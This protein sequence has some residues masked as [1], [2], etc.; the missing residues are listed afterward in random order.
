MCPWET[1]V[2]VSV[3]DSVNSGWKPPHPIYSDLIGP[4]AAGELGLHL[5]HGWLAA[6]SLNG[7]EEAGTP[8]MLE[9]ELQYNKIAE[10]NIRAL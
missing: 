7:V 2:W 8:A 6:V 9:N 10:D 1:T 5:R 4:A 3:Q